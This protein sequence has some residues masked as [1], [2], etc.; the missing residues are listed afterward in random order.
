MIRDTFSDYTSQDTI[1]LFKPLMKLHTIEMVAAHYHHRRQRQKPKSE[2]ELD[3]WMAAAR[4]ALAG[5]E[6]RDGQIH[7]GKRIRMRYRLIDCQEPA[8]GEHPAVQGTFRDV[9]V[10]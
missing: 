3:A 5:H 8:E 7:G 4:E 2:G 10:D 6:G 1:I 9:E